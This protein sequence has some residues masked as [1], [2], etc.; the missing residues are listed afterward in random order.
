[1]AIAT[2][3]EDKIA[4]SVLNALE[5]VSLDLVKRLPKT[6]SK[7]CRKPLIWNSWLTDQRGQ[8]LGMRT[9]CAWAELDHGTTIAIIIPLSKSITTKI[10]K[11]ACVGWSYMNVCKEMVRQRLH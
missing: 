11:D 6:E 10:T 5:D 2:N 3:W 7:F 4:W 1:M 8:M 9:R